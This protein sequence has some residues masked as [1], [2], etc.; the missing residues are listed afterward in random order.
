MDMN[1]INQDILVVVYGCIT[2]LGDSGYIVV[3]NLKSPN[4]PELIKKTNSSV[5]SVAFSNQI[6]NI[7]AC[8]CRD[9]SLYFFDTTRGLDQ[10]ISQTTSDDNLKHI[11]AIWSLQWVTKGNTES[12]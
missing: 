2:D 10:P 11:D 6:P 3:W 7:F 8:G 5:L 12:H 1:K 9:G 4:Q